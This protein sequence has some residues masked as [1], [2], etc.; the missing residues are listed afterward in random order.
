MPKAKTVI[1]DLGTTE[2]RRRRRVM[3]MNISG[4]VRVRVLD[5]SEIDRL[6]CDDLITPS[7]HGALN[8][9]Q[10]DL[11]LA[12]MTGPRAQNYGRPISSGHVSEMSEREALRVMRASSAI[13]AII[14][15]AGR[16][17]YDA[18]VNLCI[19]DKR[20]A[21]IQPVKDAAAAYIIWRKGVA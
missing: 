7:E 21:T 1:S 3:P 5:S 8:D 4:V 14:K 2:F 9:F 13:A 16:A 12:S 10:N 17:A 18:A 15:H 6:L 20:P 19:A 11:H